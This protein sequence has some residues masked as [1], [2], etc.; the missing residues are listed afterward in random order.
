MSGPTRAN[1]C[2]N[3]RNPTT[4]Q[5]QETSETKSILREVVMRSLVEIS[6][7]MKFAFS[8][9]YSSPRKPLQTSLH[10]GYGFEPTSREPFFR[11]ETRFLD[12][13]TAQFISGLFNATRCRSNHV[14]GLNWHHNVGFLILSYWQRGCQQRAATALP[15]RNG[16]PSKALMPTP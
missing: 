16:C 8:R 2:S 6:C 11:H 1:A 12:N 4:H 9:D 5:G 14:A 13:I 7:R 10:N 15:M 3:A